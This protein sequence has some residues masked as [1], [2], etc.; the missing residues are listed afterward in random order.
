M[1]KGGAAARH[2]TDCS[3]EMMREIYDR[4]GFLRGEQLTLEFEKVKR[5]VQILR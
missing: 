4:A 5:T 3:P 1:G 2:H